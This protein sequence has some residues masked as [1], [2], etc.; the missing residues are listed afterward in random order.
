MSFTHRRNP[1]LLDTDY[2]F[3]VKAG[4]NLVCQLGT[5]DN[6]PEIVIC[7]DIRMNSNRIINLQVP[8]LPHEVANKFYVDQTPRKILNGYIPI[9]R[10]T[11]NAFSN[12]KFGFVATA[13]SS[14][15][16]LFLPSNAF[17]GVYSRGS[18]ASSEWATRGES[19]NFW[20][21]IKCPDLVRVWKI[22]LRGR[23]S[24]TQRIYNWRLEGSTDGQNY[25]ALLEPPNP[26]YIGNELEYYLIETEDKY[27]IYR[28]FCL[29]AEPSHPG[30]SYFQ[31]YVY[32]E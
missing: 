5:S 12:D 20:I 31:L 16:N 1:V 24:N 9:L 11:S 25:T 26:S 6:T 2:G 7:K 23:D 14:S 18:G 30:L 29:E 15:T 8:Q 4:N 13:S 27:N 17:N 19:E 22:A 32:S 28:L 21:Q 10:A 3:I